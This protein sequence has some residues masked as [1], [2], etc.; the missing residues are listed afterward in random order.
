MN[1]LPLFS[2]KPECQFIPFP[3][4]KRI[5]KARKV[6]ETWLSYASTKEAN[7]YARRINGDLVRHLE[8]IG[9]PESRH[10]ELCDQFWNL[11][12]SEVSRQRAQRCHHDQRQDEQ[13]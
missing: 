11:V 5:G 10:R 9:V 13:A 7:G 8:K 6:A 3:P 2:W 12:R 1:D 4:D